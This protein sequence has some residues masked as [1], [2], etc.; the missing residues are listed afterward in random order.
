MAALVFAFM[1]VAVALLSMDYLR[2][3]SGA[4]Q[5]GPLQDSADALLGALPDDVE[6]AVLVLR[7]SELQYNRLRQRA[8]PDGAPLGDLLIELSKP[9]NGPVVFAS[10]GLAALS[11]PV[12]NGPATTVAVRGGNHWS[13]QAENLH[14]RVRLLEPTVADTTALRWFAGNLV[15]P[16]LIAFALVLIP[17]WWAVRRGLSPLRKLTTEVA[18]RRV[19]DFAP[20][21]LDLRY[22]E[23]QPLVVAFNHLLDRSRAAVARERAFVQDAAHELRTPLAAIAAQAH[24]LA[25]QPTGSARHQARVQLERLIER[26][27]HQVHQLLTLARLAG[28]PAREPVLLDC[29]NAVRAAL[30]AAAPVALARGIELSLDAPP[31]CLV[32]LDAIAFHSVLDNLLGNALAHV[33]DGAQIHVT[34]RAANQQLVLRVADNGPGIAAEDQPHLFER[35]R[36]G[37][38]V[39]APGCGL[40]LAI[41]REAAQQLGGEVRF[42]PGLDGR[43]VTFEVNLRNA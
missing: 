19:D 25:A 17:L 26:A 23:L 31:C 13:V 24:A 21:A 14:W 35:F 43:G 4:A 42:G 7:A 5:Q 32:R 30:I 18:G 38:N 27:S 34:L 20:L 1:L 10:R 16:M 12:Q 41:V 39:T 29:A 40:G 28:V 22:A 9:L 37:R 11:L 15:R 8:G 33:Q 6:D 36:R 3:R 2:F